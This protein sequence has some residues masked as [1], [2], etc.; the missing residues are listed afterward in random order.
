MAWKMQKL[1]QPSR[2]GVGIAFLPSARCSIARPIHG[3][4]TTGLTHARP[5]LPVS[6]LVCVDAHAGSLDRFE[7]GGSAVRKTHA[8]T[9]DGTLDR[10]LDGAFHFTAKMVEEFRL[11]P[12]PRFALEPGPR[13]TNPPG[14][15]GTA[16]IAA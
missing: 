13:P 5:D 4:R 10:T 14:A 2:R 7:I 3:I 8:A 1:K 11:T 12:D 15:A 16:R 9:L 6:A